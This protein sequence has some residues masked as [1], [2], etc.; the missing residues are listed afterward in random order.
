MTPLA[1]FP[2]K[3]G[4]AKPPRNPACFAIGARGKFASTVTSRIQAGLFDSQTRPGKPMPIG[5]SCVRECSPN[6][7][8][9]SEPASQKAGQRN[10]PP[11]SSWSHRALKTQSPIE[12]IV[13]R[14]AELASSS[15]QEP[16]SRLAT[17]YWARRRRS[18]STRSVISRAILEAPMMRPSAVL[19]GDTVSETLIKRPSLRRRTF[20]LT[21]SPRSL[22]YVLTLQGVGLLL[23][24]LV[25][26]ALADRYDRRRMMLASDLARFGLVAGLTVIDG[27]GHLGMGILLG[28]AFAEGL[29][30]GFFTPALGGV[31]AP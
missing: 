10:I 7:F 14:M 4:N 12:A 9:S 26:G 27:T 11:A 21:G 3:S 25:G 20:T 24:V 16:A 29:A 17:V 19:I 18:R 15:V 5:K 2:E 1:A 28:L 6:F 13:W 30:T 23:T 8:N 22:G 31:G